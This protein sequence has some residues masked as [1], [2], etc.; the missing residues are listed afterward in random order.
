VSSR[1][2]RWNQFSGYSI[3]RTRTRSLK[4]RP[5]A[6]L[7]LLLALLAP[8]AAAQ[9]TPVQYAQLTIRQRVVIRVPRMPAAPPAPVRWEERKGPKCIA[10]ADLAGAL[11]SSRDA[12]DLVLRG[13]RRLRAKLDDECR[14]M[15]FYS[16]FYLRPSADGQVCAKRDSFRVRSGATC[17]VGRFRLLTPK[18]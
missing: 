13:G 1:D 9:D 11:V 7:S 18:Q 3:W 14:S 10:V 6:L 5:L 8:A 4:P 17:P 2:A 12:I 16:G 15:D